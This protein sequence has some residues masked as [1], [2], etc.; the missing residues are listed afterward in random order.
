MTRNINYLRDLML[1]GFEL[2]R[3]SKVPMLYLGNPGMGKTTVVN[4]WA[5]RNG[6]HVESLIGSAFD[7]S[8]IL[9]Y[10]VNDGGEW[11]RTKDPEW[12]HS[13]VSRQEQGVPSVLQRRTADYDQASIFRNDYDAVELFMKIVDGTRNSKERDVML[14]SLQEVLVT[15]KFYVNTCIC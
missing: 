7:R 9:G 15:Y 13:I 11:L 5:R 10:M 12:F 14:A 3:R 8:E 6:Y 1:T 2:S 4:L